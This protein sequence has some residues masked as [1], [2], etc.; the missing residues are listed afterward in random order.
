MLKNLVF[1][2]IQLSLFEYLVKRCD[3]L[4]YIRYPSRSQLLNYRQTLIFARFRLSFH[5]DIEKPEDRYKTRSPGNLDA[6]DEKLTD[7]RIIRNDNR[8]DLFRTVISP[9]LFLHLLNISV[10]VSRVFFGDRET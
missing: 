3:R 5:S 4:N 6:S 7:L 8:L 9:D 1:T 10:T 2:D